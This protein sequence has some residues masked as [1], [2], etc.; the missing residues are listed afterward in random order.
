M[1]QPKKLTRD[2]KIMLSRQGYNPKQY[3]LIRDLP[4]YLVLQ[5]RKTA[6]EVVVDKPDRR[7]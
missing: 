6:L 5:D 4:Y 3:L 1:K 7:R 2:Q